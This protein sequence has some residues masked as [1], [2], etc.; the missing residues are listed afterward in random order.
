VP[1]ISLAAG[2]KR[3]LRRVAVPLVVLTTAT[4]GYL[5]YA[6]SAPVR[7]ATTAGTT[8]T[9]ASITGNVYVSP[10]GSDGNPGTAAAPVQTVQ[11]AQA[12]V[13]GLNT[14]MSADVTVV[15]ADGFYRMSSPLTLTAADS[16]TNGHNVIWTADRGAR[17]VLAGSAQITGWSKISSGSAIWVAQAPAGIQTRQLYVNGERAARANGA[18]PNSLTGQN[19]T[20]YSGGGSAMAAWRNPSGVSPQLEFVYR[21]GLGAW[22]EPRCPVASFS[23]SAVNMAQPC[24]TNSTARAG[25]FPDGRAYNLVGRSSITEQPTSVENAFQ[26]LSSSTPGQWF[27]DQGDSKLYYVPRPGEAMGSVDVEAPVLEKLVTGGGSSS[28]PLHNVVFNGLQFSYATW[29]GPQFHTQGTSDGFS[30]IQAGYQVTG[31]NGAAAQGLCHIP[32]P[33]YTLGTCPFGAWTQTPGNVS[34]THDQNIQFTGDAFAH[35]G[36]AGLALGDGSQH[37]VVKGNVVTDVSGNGIELGNVDQ[38]TASGSAQTL[39]NSVTDNHVFNVPV[40]FHG[41]VG[42]DSGY[43]ASDTVSHNQIDHTP[44]TAISQGWGGWPDKEQEAPQANFSHD[45][46][47]SNNLIFDHMSLLNDGGAIYTQGI[48]GTSLAN[49]EHVT[50]NVIHDQ[51]GS[52][53]VIYTDNGCTFETIT[54]N[55]VYNNTTAQAWASRHTDYAPGATTTYD[56]TDV[57]NNYFQ[58]PAGYTTGGG[59]TVANNTTIT[60]ASGVP[61]AITA[62][63]GIEAAYQGVLS[64]VQAP[65]PTVPGAPAKVVLSSLT[66]NDPA[67]AANWSLQTNLQVGAAIY[68]DR[69]YTVATLPT[70]LIGAQWVRVANNSKT[71]TTDPLV[72][73]AISKSATVYLA[74][75]VRTGKRPWMDASWLDTGSTLTDDESGTTRTFEVYSKGFAAGTVSLGP[76]AA[77]NDGYDIA[78]V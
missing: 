18:L 13:R 35:L 5:G 26:F 16:G 71:V 48:T 56:P 30:E 70:P 50:G 60:G 4:F 1:T 44:Y 3:T 34:L 63:A 33:S 36:A 76:N 73:F 28:A 77:N 42:I 27:L 65:L 43:T 69:A 57:E 66:V 8:G 21:G 12:L 25:S 49:G 32:P 46:A 55:A 22:T 41:G 39:G 72:T 75:D 15:L 29:L 74:V 10:N 58:N 67:N 62:N 17:P 6:Y 54:G 40:E 59:V 20:G 31:P 37:D 68:G 78:V 23:G 61:A 53:H 52:G 45:N 19:S 47:I 38:P 11:R 14:S 9:T 2:R 64:W 51:T 7:T 24:W